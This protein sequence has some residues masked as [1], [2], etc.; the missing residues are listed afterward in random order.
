MHKLFLPLVFT[1]AGLAACSSKPIHVDESFDSDTPNQK[2]FEAPL[3][4][5]CEGTRLAM[6]SQGDVINL[7]RPH[8]MKAGKDFQP[9][10]NVHVTME[11]NVVCALTRAGST[12][13]M[14]ARESRY[15]LQTSMQSTSVSLPVWD[16]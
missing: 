2:V 6:L 3:A 15:D 14:T 12:L 16:H 9:Q 1:L 5:V 11:L 4:Q 8:Q 13:F 7:S 10:N